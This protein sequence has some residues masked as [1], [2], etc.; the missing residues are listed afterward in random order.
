MKTLEN[1]RAERPKLLNDAITFVSIVDIA[2][3]RADV[4][5]FVTTPAYWDQWHPATRDVRGVPE[6]PLVEG[7]TMVEH[8]SAAGRKFDAVWTVLYCE[9]PNTWM[10]A[11]ETQ[12]G[13][14]CVTYRL[15]E[16]VTGCRFERTLDF[17]S[18]VQPWRALDSTLVRLML[19]RQ[20]A[21]A[22]KNLKRLL[23]TRP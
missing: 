17:R 10:F 22:L 4:F 21:R 2:C 14:A 6:R 7:E 11:T 8:I 12:R 9:A 13:A 16:R 20:T 18:K 3:A 23:E 19:Q 1:A 15:H 5:N